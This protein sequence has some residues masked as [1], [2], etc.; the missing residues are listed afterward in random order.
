MSRHSSLPLVCFALFLAAPAHA[1][2]LRVCAFGLH[3]P[4]EIDAFK[5]VLPVEDFEVLDL[6]PPPVLARS[7][8]ADAHA[9]SEGA[10]ATGWLPPLCRKDLRCDVVIYSAE[11]AGRFFGSSGNSISLQEME[12]AS[13][14]PQCDGLF[15]TPL[16]VFLL[17]CNTLATKDQ[18]RRTPAEYLQVLMREGAVIVKEVKKNKRISYGF[19][20][21]TGEYRDMIEAG[22]IDPTT[23]ARTALQNAASIAG[24]MIT[25]E[26]I[27][28]DKPEKEKKM[29]GRRPCPPGRSCP[30][31]CRDRGAV[32]AHLD[33]APLPTPE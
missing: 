25:T 30:D 14:R 8:G 32:G 31:Q 4:H 18:D 10:R 23:V 15:H 11:F 27:I 13:C 3:S 29:P 21:A 20:A 16:E 22:I 28:A 2:R 19:N 5:N 33:G 7:P 24:L 17:A 6:S 12:E 1:E 9:E 26:C